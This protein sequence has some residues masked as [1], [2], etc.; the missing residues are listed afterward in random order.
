M[1][2]SAV[3]S[4]KCVGKLRVGLPPVRSRKNN[5]VQRSLKILGVEKSKWVLIFISD[6]VP[7]VRP[8]IGL[9]TLQ[10]TQFYYHVYD[11]DR[12]QLHR[13]HLYFA[14]ITDRKLL[15]LRALILENAQIVDHNFFSSVSGFKVQYG[16]IS[17]KTSYKYMLRKIV[18]HGRYYIMSTKTTFHQAISKLAC[19]ILHM[20]RNKNH[21]RQRKSYF[22][23]KN[24]F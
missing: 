22:T 6:V 18:L 19:I 7:S 17:F 11:A 14:K 12:K 16:C 3:V 8:S 13:Y 21:F 23:T 15:I 1:A 4:L 9:K 10:N 5:S 20:H 2:I 24:I